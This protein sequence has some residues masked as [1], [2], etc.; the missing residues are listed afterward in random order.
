MIRPAK[1]KLKRTIGEGTGVGTTDRVTLSIATSW[2][3][4]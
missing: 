3:R 4:E 1:P 2:S